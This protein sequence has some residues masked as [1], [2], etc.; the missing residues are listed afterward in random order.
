MQAW[1]Q[2]HTGEDLEDTT[3]VIGSGS[4]V[5][6]PL[7]IDTP[8]PP[9]VKNENPVNSIHS[10]GSMAVNSINKSKHFG[11][12]PANRKT[13]D[14]NVNGHP[15]ETGKN[16]DDSSSSDQE[17]S[18]R[19]SPP[20]RKPPKVKRKKG[21]TAALAK[22][23][24]EEK[25]RKGEKLPPQ[26]ESGSDSDKESDSTKDSDSGASTT[27]S[28]NGGGKKPGKEPRKRG[29]RPKGSKNDKGEEPR[30]K[31]PKEEPPRDP[32]RKPPVS[33]LK[34]T[35]ESF[36]QDGPCFEVAPK[37]AKCRECR[38]TPNQR[39]RNMPNIFCRFYAF[40]RLRYTKNG[41][42]AIAGFSDPHKD[43]MEV[44]LLLY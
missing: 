42:L 31:K 16:G 3:G 10:V 37:L 41:Q 25:K 1:L 20:K 2:R 27:V 26:S 35:G 29:R 18:G 36:L 8:S 6:L 4:C 19:K 38:W 33:Q 43:A 14:T 17:R 13:K 12:K 44:C 40:R 11:S 24:A 9:P 7:N 28:G 30:A 5:T 32:F 39:S 34:K 21:A 15:S 23:A 22:K